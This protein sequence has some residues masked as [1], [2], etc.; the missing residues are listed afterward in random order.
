MYGNCEDIKVYKILVEN[1]SGRCSEESGYFS[2]NE[3]TP[4]SIFL[5]FPR[6]IKKGAVRRELLRTSNPQVTGSIPV[7]GA[8]L[9]GSSVGRA[10]NV[11]LQHSPLLLFY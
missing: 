5:I 1:K 10:V 2:Q 3:T 8:P 4:A 9:Q 6:Y 11:S 7:F